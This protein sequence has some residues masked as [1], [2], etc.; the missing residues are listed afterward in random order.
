MSALAARLGLRPTDGAPQWGLPAGAAV[1]TAGAAAV[2]LGPVAFAIPFGIAVV[3]LFV[4]FPPALLV[5]YGY[6]GVFKGEKVFSDLPFDATIALAIL[7]LGVCV[8]RLLQRRARPVPAPFVALLVL[9]AVMLAVSLNWTPMPAYGTEKVLKFISLTALAAIS[10][11]FIVRD[12][13]DLRTLL[14][15]TVALAI[16]GAGIALAEPGG[17][18][19][20]RIEFGGNENTI[21]TSRLLCAGALVLLVA[22][23]LGLPRRLRMASPLLGVGLVL[24]AAGVGSRGPI[25]ALALALACVLAA[26]LVK[27]P[28][29]LVSVLVIVGV[30]L[31]IFPLIQ[32]PETSRQRL[33]QTVND[34]VQT[35]ETDGRSRMY[36]K[37]IELASEHP[38]LGFGSGG[39]FLYSYVLM[40]QEEKYPHNI[41]LELASEVGLVPPIA[42]AVAV[43]FVIVALGRRAFRAETDRDRRLMFVLGG[44]FLNNL[45]AVQFS[46]D[47][48]DNRV[49][50]ATFGVA[51]LLAWYGIPD[52]TRGPWL[53]LW[54]GAARQ[55]DTSSPPPE[56]R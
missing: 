48:N 23:A 3:A 37:A 44:L 10:P 21:F 20:G 11:F 31:A 46:G 50:W 49:F 17:A 25:V 34:P 47:I 18:E 4:R 32:L 9:I 38:V 43:L 8:H 30:G 2:L 1:I 19:S 16:F 42:L 45:F 5:T 12:R 15:A 41:F 56:G 14:W 54:P 28:R 53:G 22:P 26:S 55:P 6:I 36:T 27:N 40:D 51:W 39:F 52:R 33:E 29:Q 13:T 24:V 35:L 7:L